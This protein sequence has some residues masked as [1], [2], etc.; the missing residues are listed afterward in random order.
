MAP[1]L[2]ARRAAGRARD[3]RP[4]TGSAD[5]FSLYGDPAD[6]KPGRHPASY[7]AD[8]YQWWRGRSGGSAIR[9]DGAVVDEH[10]YLTA[11]IAREASAWITE[12]SR[13]PLR[14]AYVPFNARTHRCK[15][16]D[17]RSTG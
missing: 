16:G 9:R 3:S 7:F 17:A 5:A 8:R 1:R 2:R 4:S 12:T 14:F 15:R 6:P 10:E 11:A 13:R